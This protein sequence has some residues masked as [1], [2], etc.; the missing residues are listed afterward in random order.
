M[1][2]RTGAS[3]ST[4]TYEKSKFNDRTLTL[5]A[6]PRF[7]FEKFDLR[8]ELTA[9]ARR[10][11]GEMYSRAAG[12]ELSGNWQAAPAWRLSAAVGGERVSYETFLGE[13]NMY[14]TQVGLSPRTRARHVAASRW[15]ISPRGRGQ[16][17]LFMARVHCRGLGHAG[18]SQGLRGDRGINL[19][20]A[21]LR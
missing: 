1:R 11:G 17:G 3:L 2:F 10:L 20:V 19:Q 4:R 18:A 13:G 14:S 16:R 21:A 7:L 12:V 9:R 8:P 15:C 5:R 6:G